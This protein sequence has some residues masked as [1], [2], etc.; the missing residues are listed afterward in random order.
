MWTLQEWEDGEA[1]KI[2]EEEY[3][4]LI[5]DLPPCRAIQH[6][7]DLQSRLNKLR[8]RVNCPPPPIPHR[9]GQRHGRRH[10]GQQVLDAVGY[11]GNQRAWDQQ[12]RQV[13]H[14]G[15]LEEKGTP[16]CRHPHGGEV[17]IIV[18]LFSG[19]RR[20]GDFHSQLAQL[21]KEAP[22]YVKILS[23][24]TA[25]SVDSGNLAEGSPSWK[26]IDRMFSKGMV[27]FTLAG[28]PCETFSEARHQ[29]PPPQ[30][31]GQETQ[32]QWPRP[33]RSAAEL[34]GLPGLKMKE[35][36]QV[37]VGSI[38]HLQTLYLLIQTWR[39]GGAFVSEHPAI[40]SDPTIRASTWTSPVMEAIRRLHGI[41]LNH[42]QQF[43]WGA[44]TVKPT[45][46]LHTRLP[47]FWQSMSKWQIP[48][49]S[50][51]EK[52]AIGKD[53]SGRF[54]T[55]KAKE[56]PTALGGAFAQLAYDRLRLVHGRN[57]GAIEM[58]DDD[59]DFLAWYRAASQDS[60][61]IRNG[62]YLPDYQPANN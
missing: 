26:H 3:Y 19:R 7:E 13:R 40:P 32:R 4:L 57:V 46:L 5:K 52:V 30:E 2:V 22:F 39:G 18:H 23:L 9:Q 28:S 54:N 31:E 49:V 24:D 61:V 11:Y 38:L 37:Q 43:R 1:E 17:Y 48:N 51:P 42:I 33:L 16:L 6:G 60:G 59:T 45:A 21:C 55:A 58:A 56:Y 29:A 20:L 44:E 10:V 50:Y 62:T 8:Q 14:E 25:V 41:K 35:L 53:A 27:A 47:H 36:Q 12:L 34:W 15:E